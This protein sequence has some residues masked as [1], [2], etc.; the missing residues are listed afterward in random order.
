[1]GSADQPRHNIRVDA[2]ERDIGFDDNTVVV[3]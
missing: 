3:R 2:A 1:M